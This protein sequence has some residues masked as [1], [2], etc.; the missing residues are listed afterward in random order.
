VCGISN[1]RK[2]IELKSNLD[3]EKQ[4]TLESLR[5]MREERDQKA[6]ENAENIKKLLSE[7]K[8]SSIPIG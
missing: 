2:A 1:N 8:A 6:K 3:K 4:E 7:R 5:I